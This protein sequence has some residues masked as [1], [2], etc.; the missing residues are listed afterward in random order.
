LNLS[1][2]QE[3]A[4]TTLPEAE[5]WKISLVYLADNPIVNPAKMVVSSRISVKRKRQHNVWS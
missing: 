2:Q 5:Q 4:G 1:D 3:Q